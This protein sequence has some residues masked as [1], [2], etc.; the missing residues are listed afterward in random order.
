MNTTTL[1]QQD[2]ALH[3]HPC[4]QM[5][6]YETFK[7]LVIKKAYDCYFELDN[8]KKIID[9]IS[10]WWCKSLGHNHPELKQALLTQLEKFEHVIFSNTTHETIVQLSKKLTA[11]SPHLKKVFYAGGDGSSA[12]ETAL[13]MSLHARKNKNQTQRTKF[14]A[15]KNGYHGETVGAMSVS[16]LGLYREPYQSLL[17]DS[18]FIEPLYVLGEDDVQWHDAADYWKLIE[19]KLA[20]H[21]QTATAI[22]L[23][24]IVQGAAGM[25]IYSADFLSRLCNFAKQN[26]IHVIA[27]EIMTGIGRCGKMLACEYANV[28]PDFVCLSKGLTAGFIPLSAVL[29]TNEI[30]DLFYDDYET[31]KSFLHSHTYSGYALGAAVALTTLEIIEKN[32]YCARANALQKIMRDSMQRIAEKTGALKNIRGVGAIVAADLIVPNEIKR[33]GYRVFQKAVELGAWLRP[34]GNTIYWFPPLTISDEL[35][36]AL[37]RITGESIRFTT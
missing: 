19:K 10:S 15:L 36:L 18:I 16:D 35:I 4:A 14:I 13:K 21:A 22:I 11:L 34:L 1:Q 29:T 7:P 20:L 9:A 33:A 32:N 28:Y 12:V 5:K 25:K 6:D 24:P 8:G 23:E 2:H 27:D 3:W 31:E 17:F 37:E 30:Y 26:D